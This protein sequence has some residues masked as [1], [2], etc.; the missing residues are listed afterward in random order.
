VDTRLLFKKIKA[1]STQGDR[2]LNLFLF[3]GELFW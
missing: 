3:E 2:D 1:R